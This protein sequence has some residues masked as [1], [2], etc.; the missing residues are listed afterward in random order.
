M[1]TGLPALAAG[2]GQ[3][4]SSLPAMGWAIGFVFCRTA[5]F[6]VLDMQGDRIVGKE[7]LPILLGTKP[8]LKLLKNMLILLA[9]INILAG[10]LGMFANLVFALAI[11]P[12]LLWLIIKLHEYDQ[13]LPGARTEFMVEG[14]FFLAGL[15]TLAYRL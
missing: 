5:F 1:T 14:L 6:D 15:I 13:T 4:F 2:E 7:T 3:W 8:T 12:L 10:A 9:L 11:C